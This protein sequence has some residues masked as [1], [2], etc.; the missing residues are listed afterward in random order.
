M[1]ILS[2][3]LTRLTTILIAFLLSSTISFAQLDYT[4]TPVS[5][6]FTAIT[7]GTDLNSMEGDDALS[8]AINI[9]FTFNYDGADYTQVKVSSNGWVTFNLTAS[10][11]TYLNNLDLSSTAIR[12]LLAP[13][14]DDFD[15]SS[16]TAKYITTGT[17]PNRAFT[18]ECLNALW[19]YDAAGAVISY[20]VILYETTNIIEFVYKQEANAATDPSASI[21]ITASGTGSGT[22]WS[23]NGTGASPTA[24]STV[25]TANLSTK[26]ATGQI[27]RFSPPTC[28][29]PTGLAASNITATQA[30]LSWTDNAGALLWDIE[31]GLVDFIPTQ[32]PTDW[33]VSNFDT[34]TGLSMATSYDYYVRADCG[35]SDYSTWEGPF[36]F[37]TICGTAVAPSWN[38]D[39]EN[40]G[41]IPSCW[42]QGASNSEDW[43]FADQSSLPAFPHVGNAG[44][45]GSSTTTSGNYIAWVDDGSPDNTGTTLKSP[46]IDVSA[47]SNPYLSFY[48]ISHNEGTTNVDFSVD[49]WDGT[50]WNVGYYTHNTNTLDGEWELIDVNLTSLTISGA[51]QLRFIVDENNGTDYKDDIAIDDVKIYEGISCPVP[52]SLTAG[53]ITTTEAVLSWT[54]NAGVLLFDIEFGLAN[55][56]Q[57][58]TPTDWGVSNSYTYPGLSPGTSYEYYVRADCGASDYSDWEGP[59]PFNTQVLV[60]KVH[61]SVTGG[62]PWTEYDRMELAFDAINAGTHTGDITINIGDVDGQT[63][64]ETATASLNKSGSGSASYTSVT[65]MPGAAN[66]KLVSNISS[67]T[68][69]TTSGTVYLNAAENV[70][71]DGRIG[72]AGS[73]IDLTIE[74]TSTGI[75]AGAFAFREAS[76]NIL[77]YC[78]LKSSITSISGGSGTISFWYSSNNLVEDCH[79]TKSG[80]NLPMHAISSLG[81]RDNI[82]NNCNIYD[83]QKFGVFLGNTS[84]TEGGN[85]QWTIQSNTIYQ[86]TSFTGMFKEQIGICIGYPYSSSG[87]GKQENGTFTI[88]DNTIGGNG[89]GGY[90]TWS[91]GA[92]VVAGIYLY[93]TYNSDSLYSTI[94]GNLIT[95]FDIESTN[96]DLGSSEK[97]VFTGIISNNCKAYI[98]NTKANTIGSLT[99]DDNIKFKSTV[100]TGNVFGISMTTPADMKNR[101]INNV[102][103]GISITEGSGGM[104]FNGIRIRC[105]TTNNSDS[106]SQNNVSYITTTQCNKFAGISANGYVCKNRIRDID[107]TGTGASSELVGIKWDGGDVL[108]RGVEN[109]E[110]ILGKNKAGA[111]VA[112]NDII[113]GVDLLN[114]CQMYYNSIYIGGTATGSNNTTG[115]KV[116]ASDM[117]IKN[118]FVY[119][120][121]DGG[122]GDIYG[123]YNSGPFAW[124]SNNNAY[125][126]NAGAKANSYLGYWGGSI[127]TLATWES[128]TSESNSV[129]DTPTNKPTATMFPLLSTQNNLDV[130]DPSFLDAGVAVIEEIDIRDNARNATP[131]IGAYE[132][133]PAV[134]PVEL[135]T[136]TGS[137]NNGYADLAWET[138]S[139][140]NNDYFLL[141][142]SSDA[143]NWID[144]ATITGAGNSNSL[145]GYQYTDNN[146]F[147]GINYYRLKQVD[148]DGEFVYS[149]TIIINCNSEITN[150]CLYPN[151]ASGYLSFSFKTPHKSRLG[152]VMVNSL[153]QQVWQSSY[154]I[155]NGDSIINT[156]VS[157]LSDGMYLVKVVTIDGDVVHTDRLIINND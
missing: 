22:F 78:N 122:A 39:F 101:I 7:G 152:I 107:F 108:F 26:P 113:I 58:F 116:G 41:S 13:L 30:D 28:P 138:A 145:T 50:A 37:A 97:S 53:S 105:A 93:G 126:I 121:R 18:I 47:L 112:G 144:V 33:G 59:Y 118:N 109:N 42:S 99:D 149:E 156:D 94:D 85:R 80:S 71:I 84:V 98:G 89:S 134:L 20:Q 91:G 62:P 86:T 81:G 111:S 76:N 12:P 16:S 132:R 141:Q 6:S 102:I 124:T 24:S 155:D 82:I 129:T 139:E 23:L 88:K 79:I 27:Y 73:T 15:C 21:G 46:L 48:L 40:A 146:P 3:K 142:N 119:I 32:V 106:I 34:Y 157:S 153:G 143:S 8:S 127:S 57:T 83:F 130:P 11:S 38:E 114:K 19:D 154:D 4:F 133:S 10:N 135:L 69:G 5:G 54:D 25:E 128:T 29:A 150:I 70:I 63:I 131:T 66:I 90:W 67:T 136:F 43:V 14:W 60:G 147:N 36:T 151:P 51:I 104:T 140:I 103:S 1:K 120:E 87:S 75:E 61:L 72:A 77:K 100:G 148:Y 65:I 31:L 9:G 92:Y 137:C 2:A 17:S 117:T 110:I 123:I 68:A 74:N 64:T 45:F 115:I 56:T 95:M 49:V 52:T 35:G 44:S 96:G 55:F 125:V